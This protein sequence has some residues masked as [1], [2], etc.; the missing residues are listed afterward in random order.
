VVLLAAIE[1]EPRV[2]GNPPGVVHVEL[3]TPEELASVQTP[4]HGAAK[5]TIVLAV[6]TAVGAA[7]VKALVTTVGALPVCTHEN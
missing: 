4:E 3:I 7:M 5:P 1:V 6:V 2:I